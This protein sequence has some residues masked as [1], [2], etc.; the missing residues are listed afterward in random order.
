[1]A[2]HITETR[3]GEVLKFTD[4]LQVITSVIACD[5]KQG[6]AANLLI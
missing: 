6:D 4:G 1:M 3:W 5:E 2:D